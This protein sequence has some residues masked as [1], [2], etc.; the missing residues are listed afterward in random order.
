MPNYR[1]Q[2]GQITRD[3]KDMLE[4]ASG[5]LTVRPAGT[6]EPGS[7]SAYLKLK[8]T[9]GIERLVGFSGDL[10]CLLAT[11]DGVRWTGRAGVGKVYPDT[12]EV[13]LKGSGAIQPARTT[14][15]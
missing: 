9:R 6:N 15:Q 11:E 10:E 8:T 5:D 4:V 13:E 12:H 2:N 3:R 14:N 7:W 1:V